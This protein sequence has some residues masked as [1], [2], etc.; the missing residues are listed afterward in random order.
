MLEYI[1]VALGLLGLLSGYYFYLRSKRDI[2]PTVAFRKRVLQTRD[3]PE[4]TIRF[5]GIEV[6]TLHQLL[7]VF[8]NAGTKELR[9]QDLP[10]TN[11]LHLAFHESCRV[12]SIAILSASDPATGFS[13]PEISPNRF[14]FRFDFLNPQDGAAIEILYDPSAADGQILFEPKGSIIG[15]RSIKVVQFSHAANLLTP[16]TL[17][18]GGLGAGALATIDAWLIWNA[19]AAGDWGLAM[20]FS[21]LFL[22]AAVGLYAVFRLALESTRQRIPAFARAHF[23]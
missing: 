19:L 16:L 20:F 4:I 15:A 22:M 2:R 18:L 12:L 17:L 9:A 13:V 11:P 14:A 10:Q 23:Q 1:G 3:H 7:V 8:W 5:R 21:A 6:S